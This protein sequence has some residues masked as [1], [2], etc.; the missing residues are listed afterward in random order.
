[1][2]VA[3]TLTN[4]REPSWVVTVVLELK[5]LLSS[6]S[7]LAPATAACW[8]V[9]AHKQ[10]DQALLDVLWVLASPCSEV[11]TRADN[12]EPKLWMSVNSTLSAS[13]ERRS[14]G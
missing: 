13:C 9:S 2:R 10:G 12:C 4:P 7:S 3:S 1:M 14:W 11:G 5:S 6:W 8:L